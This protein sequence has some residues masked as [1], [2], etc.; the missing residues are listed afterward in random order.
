M[1]MDFGY[2]GGKSEPAG[3]TPN[4]NGDGAS[5]T[6]LGTG[7]VGSQQVA[8]PDADEIDD[9]TGVNNGGTDGAKPSVDPATSPANQGDGAGADGDGNEQVD[10][11]P[12]SSLEVDG[13]TYTVDN[14]GNVVNADG[15]IF[16][17]AKDVQSWLATFENVDDAGDSAIS[18]NSIQEAV[19]IEILNDD[20]TPVEFENTPEGIRSYIDAVTETRRADY[21]EAAI[22]TLYQ[23]YPIINDVLNY[24]I[25]NGNSLEGFNDIPDRTNIVFDDTNEAQHENIIRTAFKEQ[26]RR[27]DVET[28][29][30]YLKSSNTLS[31]VAQ[32]ELEGIKESDRQYFAN[33]EKQAADEENSRIESLEKYWNG[34]KETVDSKVIAGYKIPDT[35]VISKD[36]QRVSVTPN[37]FFNYIYQT[38]NE[39]KS[40]YE[41]DLKKETPESRREDELLRAYLKFTGGSYASLVGMAVNEKNINTLKLKAKTKPT[42]SVK[43]TKPVAAPAKGSNIDVGYN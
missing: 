1:D 40:A 38:D 10:L 27:G 36:G 19:G 41:R 28:Y 32:E 31:A 3:G 22:N 18:I 37:D 29:I 6:D 11:Q 35:I 43:I 33:L 12:G 2:N 34:V 13:T 14:N 26:N 39:G 30:Q 17:E 21:Q 7:K 25:A 5:S 42:S 8:A 24:Y 4:A 9:T 23:K 15:S 20:D 16:K